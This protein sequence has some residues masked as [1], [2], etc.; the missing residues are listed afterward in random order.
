MIANTSVGRAATFLPYAVNSALERYGF[1][2]LRIEAS[3][4]LRLS[5]SNQI[6]IEKK[7]DCVTSL[8]RVL[9]EYGLDLMRGLGA[10]SARSAV[11]TSCLMVK[12]DA[13]GNILPLFQPSGEPPAELAGDELGTAV[14]SPHASLGR[15]LVSGG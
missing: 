9:R 2:M 4:A 8:R 15:R 11:D 1:Q 12:R 14:E 10:S 7:A 3:G 6:P 5:I 13:S